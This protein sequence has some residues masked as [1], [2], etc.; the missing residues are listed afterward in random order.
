[1]RNHLLPVHVSS[2]VFTVPFTMLVMFGSKNE[3][4]NR[5]VAIESI[6]YS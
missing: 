5:F 4:D 2:E 1:M 6:D 3:I